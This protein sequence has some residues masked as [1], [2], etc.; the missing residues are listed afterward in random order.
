[1]RII[2]ATDRAAVHR[3]VTRDLARDPAVTRTAA[4][5]IA[6]VR[7]H[8]D[9]ALLQWTQKLDGPGGQFSTG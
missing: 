7:R 2:D 4:R 6:D 1:M 5:I 3:L 9:A 8:G